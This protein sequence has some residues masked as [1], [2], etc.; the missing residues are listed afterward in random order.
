MKR[1]V[2]NRQAPES[3]NV[4]TRSNN[5]NSLAH[6]LF[7]TPALRGYSQR[8]PRIF[9]QDANQTKLTPTIVREYQSKKQVQGEALPPLE[10]VPKRARVLTEES[11]PEYF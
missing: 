9:S 3:P 5:K 11:E 1:S 6:R 8:R 7:D 4:L 10:I 2:P